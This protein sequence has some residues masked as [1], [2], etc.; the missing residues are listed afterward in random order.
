[1]PRSIPVASMALRTS[2]LGK[3]IRMVINVPRA[4]RFKSRFNMIVR[5]R[6]GHVHPLDV[7]NP[8]VG[9]Q[10]QKF[11]GKVE[12]AAFAIAAFVADL[13]PSVSLD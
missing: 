5:S 12:A 8:T 2:A 7:H 4:I 9:L 1:M 6:I 13:A 3:V 10:L 11:P